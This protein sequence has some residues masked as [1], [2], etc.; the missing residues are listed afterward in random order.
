[1]EN[2]IDEERLRKIIRE[3]LLK[4]AKVVPHGALTKSPGRAKFPNPLR[5]FGRIAKLIFSD[6]VRE[7]IQ[8]DLPINPHLAP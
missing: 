4:E 2:Y 6:P 3:T 5:A 8:Y 1:M 7:Q